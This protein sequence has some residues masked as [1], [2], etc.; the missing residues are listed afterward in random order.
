[1]IK[2]SIK[3]RYDLSIKI[4]YRGAFISNGN[5]IKIEDDPSGKSYMFT[6]EPTINKITIR[7]KDTTI[8][9]LATFEVKAECMFVSSGLFKGN[10]SKSD[11][12]ATAILD[13]V[14]KEYTKW[15]YPMGNYKIQI[16][17]S[18]NNL[19]DTLMK[20]IYLNRNEDYL[21]EFEF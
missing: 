11:N 4:F 16:V 20:D 13:N 5:S 10:F 3:F 1:L 15:N 17:R 14:N 9:Q 2:E 8:L 19:K 6:I 12:V 7:P 18:Q 21:F